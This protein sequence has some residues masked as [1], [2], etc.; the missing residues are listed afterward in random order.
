MALLGIAVLTSLVFSSGL[1]AGLSAIFIVLL[2]FKYG[3]NVIAAMSEG[4]F[5]APSLLATIT[6]GDTT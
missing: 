3:F 6:E 1:L 5:Q 2:Q 4:E